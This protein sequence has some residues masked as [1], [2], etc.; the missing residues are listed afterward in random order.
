MRPPPKHIQLLLPVWGALHTRIFLELGLP[1]L[2]ARGNIPA[3]SEL[4]ECTFVLLVP[5]EGVERIEQH[6]LWVRLQR[7]CAVAVIHIDDL[8]SESSSTVLTLAY[9]LAIR[10]SGSRALET[11]YVP[12]VAD[13]VMSD[14]SL[15]SPVKRI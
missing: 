4:C 15:Y 7:C 10:S 13:Y 6:P 2:M 1:S 8:I 12:L 9:A 14:G 5:K 3:I 11:C